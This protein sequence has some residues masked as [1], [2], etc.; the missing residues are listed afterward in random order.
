MKPEQLAFGRDQLQ[1]NSGRRSTEGLCCTVQYV[2][3]AGEATVVM[4]C[5]RIG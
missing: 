3:R 2:E 5:D 1:R 4:V